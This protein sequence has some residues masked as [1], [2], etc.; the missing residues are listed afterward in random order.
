MS[1][2][3]LIWST[4]ITK[5]QLNQ[6]ASD[7]PGQNTEHVVQRFGAAATLLDLKITTKAARAWGSSQQE[8]LKRLTIWK[9]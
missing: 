8:Q 6:G 9:Q 3:R 1:S 2:N 5:N 7:G 4:N